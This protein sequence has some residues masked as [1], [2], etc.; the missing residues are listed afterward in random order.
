MSVLVTRGTLIS[1]ESL[2]LGKSM[3]PGGS[4]AKSIMT[5]R[6]RGAMIFRA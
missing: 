5:S 1:G 4:A 3:I 6:F 2:N